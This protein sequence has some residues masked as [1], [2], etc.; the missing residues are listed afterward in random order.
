V[1]APSEKKARE[2]L[3]KELADNNL[4][5]DADKTLTLTEVPM[6]SGAIILQNG[7]Y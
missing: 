2:L 3:L 5:Q 1:V 6:R 7:D 4:P